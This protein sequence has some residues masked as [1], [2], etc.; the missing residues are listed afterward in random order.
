M[1]ANPINS[2]RNYNYFLKAIK[3]VYFLSAI[4]FLVIVFQ[5]P[6]VEVTEKKTGI[7][8]RKEYLGTPKELNGLG[9]FL[10]IPIY[11]FYPFWTFFL[12]ILNRN[13][14]LGL[15]L[16]FSIIVAYINYDLIHDYGCGILDE[17]YFYRYTF[18]IPFQFMYAVFISALH[19]HILVL[20]VI[21]K[22]PRS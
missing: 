11:V 6:E 2:Y 20:K 13:L 3:W 8:L 10:F 22:Y 5:Y 19:L 21:D 1:V 7:I 15:S 16:F 12:Y 4:A 9:M 17:S 18:V 14:G